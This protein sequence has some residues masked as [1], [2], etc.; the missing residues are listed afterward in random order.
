MKIIKEIILPGILSWLIPFIV[1]FLFYTRDGKLGV[2]IFLFKSIMLVLSTLVGC[3]L[4]IRFYNRAQGEPI[5][6][7]ITVG[8]SW[9]SINW[10]L[11]FLILLPMSK[12]SYS[13]YMIQIG[14]RYIMI[15]IISISLGIVYSNK[16]HNN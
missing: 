4:L 8:L 9:L 7:G 11:D 16:G 6:L 2:D 1:S 15:P 12:M 5:R 14:L 10:L 3:T 13:D